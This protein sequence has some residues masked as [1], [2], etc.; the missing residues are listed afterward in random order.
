MLFGHV[1]R[2]SRLFALA[3]MVEP[4]FSILYHVACDICMSYWPKF[5]IKG[6][7][8]KFNVIKLGEI[9]F[10]FVF[11]LNLQLQLLR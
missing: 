11:L 7:I 3:G 2:D 1:C 10:I 5:L 9:C 8:I 4:T 6:Q